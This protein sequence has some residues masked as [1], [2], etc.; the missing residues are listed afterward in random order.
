MPGQI[1]ASNIESVKLLYD[2]FRFGKNTCIYVALGDLQCSVYS[3]L[4]SED[5]CG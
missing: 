3:C 5:D 4:E 1:L 2:T